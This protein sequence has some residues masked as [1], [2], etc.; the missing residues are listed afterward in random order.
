MSF[1]AAT[2]SSS[3]MQLSTSALSVKRSTSASAKDAG[4]A[5]LIEARSRLGAEIALGHQ[6]LHPLVDVKALAE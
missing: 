1:I 3:T 6:R 5:V 2:P 4:S